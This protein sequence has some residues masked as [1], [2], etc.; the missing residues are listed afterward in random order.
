MNAICYVFSGT[1]NT[2]RV[3]E[4]LMEEWRA[5]G[6]EGT[7]NMMRAD[8]EAEDP[9]PYDVVIV[10]YPVHAFNAPK[11]VYTFLKKLPVAEGKPC[12]LVRTS[13]EPL[14]LNNAAG[15]VPA[16]ILKKRG[17]DVRGEYPFVMPY[18]IIFR[19]SDKVAAR[20]WRAAEG[21]L[22]SAAREMAEGGGRRFKIGALRRMASFM[23]RIEH[24]AMPV[25][26]RTFRIKKSQCIGCGKCAKVCPRGNIRM[27]NGF[28]KFGGSCVGCMGCA[29][30]C[31]KD[32]VRTSLL[33][34]WRVNG[35]YTFEGES[36]QDSEI[37]RYCRRSY[38]RYFHEMEGAAQ[39][40]C[41]QE[42]AVEEGSLPSG[43]A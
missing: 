3:C 33:N 31:P 5:L 14:K 17:Y 39:P 1:G 23:L 34:A 16:R 21:R 15:V 7:L 19:H 35:A 6:H 43:N 20:M 18:D 28:P 27:E 24:P 11:P 36:A 29:F 41:T 2:R 25:L 12:Y 26:G 42:S 9:T 40:S 38:L 22:P 37:G 10:A 13:G 32:A 4:R 8:V 30:S